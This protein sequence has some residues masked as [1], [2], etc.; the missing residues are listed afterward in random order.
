[1]SRSNFKRSSSRVNLGKPS[2]K[3]KPYSRKPAASSRGSR[4]SSPPDKSK[5]SP[6]PKWRLVLVWAVLVAGIMGLGWKLYQ[7]QIVQAKELQRKARS[8]QAVNLRPY[9]P[10]RSIIDSEGN[11]LATDMNDGLFVLGSDYTRGCYLE[12]T[13]TDYEM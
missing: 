12:G 13:V 3:R 4:R 7:L 1:M 8:Q 2:A 10:R 9:I 6:L 11:V 5:P